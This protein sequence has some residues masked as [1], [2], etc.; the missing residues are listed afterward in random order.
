MTRITNPLTV[1]GI[2]ATLAEVAG[3]IVLPSLPEVLQSYFL[4]YVIG[5]PILLVALFF[6]TLNFN[7]KALYAPSDFSNE[8]N[9]MR[10][11]LTVQQNLHQRKDETPEVSVN[12]AAAQICIDEVVETIRSYSAS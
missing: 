9:F 12:L 11:L 3:T 10:L 5:F 1:I 6:L 8:D 7:R 4:I 2:F